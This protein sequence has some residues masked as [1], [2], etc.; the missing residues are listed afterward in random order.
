MQSPFTH[1]HNLSIS[2]STTHSFHHC[3]FYPQKLIFIITLS[4]LPPQPSPLHPHIQ[5]L[6]SSTTTSPPSPLN[7]ITTS[8]PS[9]LNF[10]TTSPPSSLPQPHPHPHLLISSPHPHPHLSTSP[11]PTPPS[12][13]LHPTIFA[14]H[15][16]I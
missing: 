14:R 7:F 1:Y 6:I 16:L 9:P 5:T 10:I 2:T 4:L 12:H 3:T 8:P 11:H 15:K 13:S